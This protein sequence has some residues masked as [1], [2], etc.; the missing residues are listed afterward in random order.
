MPEEV[1]PHQSDE[2]IRRWHGALS[3]DDDVRQTLE[4]LARHE[5]MSYAEAVDKLLRLRYRYS[6]V[7]WPAMIGEPPRE[8]LRDYSP[9]ISFTTNINLP[10]GKTLSLTTHTG[11]A[12]EIKLTPRWDD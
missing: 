7:G 6:Q 5:G 1:M 12:T 10:T 2:E 11:L 4:E 9:G 3:I 8:K